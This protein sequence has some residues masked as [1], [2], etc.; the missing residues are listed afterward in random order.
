[1]LSLYISEVLG[2]N[3]A[4]VFSAANPVPISFPDI[5]FSDAL[6]T[7]IYIVNGSGGYSSASG[8]SDSQVV[9]TIGVQDA[10]LYTNITW[11]PSG[12]D[13]LGWFG[14]LNPNTQALQ[15]LFN[16]RSSMIVTIH[17]KITDADSNSRTYISMPFTLSQSMSPSSAVPVVGSGGD[18]R[19]TFPAQA[20]LY[21]GGQNR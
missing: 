5:T 11:T 6:A 10:A 13:P 2:S 14:T 17:V 12:T 21:F 1:M 7:T 8:A 15:N 19:G 9:V 4:L 18:R 20:N 16:G 3:D